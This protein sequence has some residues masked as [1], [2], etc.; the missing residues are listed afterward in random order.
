MYVDDIIVTGSSEKQIQEFN[1]RMNS[2]FDMSDM[3]K[4]NYHLGIEV[5]QEE[6]SIFIET[7][8]SLCNPTKWPMDPKL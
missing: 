1:V 5:K 8:M 3:G 2:I 4:L 6:D 7:G